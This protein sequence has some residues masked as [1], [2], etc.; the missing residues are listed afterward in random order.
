MSQTGQQGQVVAVSRAR[1]HRFH[2]PNEMSV[3]LMAGLGVEGDAHAGVTVQHLFHMKRNP[4]A[5]NLRQVHLIHAELFGDLAAAGFAVRPGELGENITTR[6]VPLLD[7]PLGTRLRLGAGALVE[8]TGLRNPCGQID[9][10]R[11]GLVAALVGHDD[12]GKRIMKAGVMAIVVEG[13]DVMAGDGITVIL[14]PLP[15][16]RLEKV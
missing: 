5:P 10:F 11:E 14:P 2:K 3:R 12:A 15:H 1:T 8:L 4:D 9:R 13:G 6:G 16:R 7:L